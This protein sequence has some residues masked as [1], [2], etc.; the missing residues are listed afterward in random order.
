MRG[1]NTTSPPIH[2][3]NDGPAI[4]S[5]DQFSLN[6]TRELACTRFV[7]MPCRR[8]PACCGA[9]AAVVHPQ[10]K[11]APHRAPTPWPTPIG[12]GRW[13]ARRK[14][15]RGVLLG[16]GRR[17]NASFHDAQS[18]PPADAA[19]QTRAVA[20]RCRRSCSDASCH[21]NATQSERGA[22]PLHPLRGKDHSGAVVSPSPSFVPG[23]RRSRAVELV[24][25]F[26]GSTA[27]NASAL[28]RRRAAV[29]RA[30]SG[31]V[32][33]RNPAFTSSRRGDEGPATGSKQFSLNVS[34]SFYTTAW[35]GC[36]APNHGSR[37]GIV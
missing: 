15:P 33:E 12:A 5:R 25:R 2:R 35:Y 36:R 17:R 24:R 14:P 8:Q 11:R 1:R 7:R 9:A 10:S 20:A 18:R 6:T 31:G 27:W 29:W 19:V 21:L 26:A 3:R 13:S 4:G 22:L 34:L 37:P 23:W 32:R 16:P 28:A 30:A